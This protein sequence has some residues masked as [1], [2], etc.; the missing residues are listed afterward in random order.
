[1][2]T[3]R[4]SI[5]GSLTLPRAEALMEGVDDRLNVMGVQLRRARELLDAKWLAG[6]PA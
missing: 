4:E 5:N 2:A 6:E 3:I 1:M